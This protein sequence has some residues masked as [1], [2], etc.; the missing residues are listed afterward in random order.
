MQKIR[1]TNDNNYFQR[2]YIINS[3]QHK[4]RIGDFKTTD[5]LLN[6]GVEQ[7]YKISLEDINDYNVNLSELVSD[8]K[9]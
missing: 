2:D 9:F 5:P 7:N 4:K 1:K 6:G 3:Y 8:A